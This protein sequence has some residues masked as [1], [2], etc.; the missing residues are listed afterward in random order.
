MT[1]QLRVV[2]Q[3]T[4]ETVTEISTVPSS[5]EFYGGKGVAISYGN[6]MHTW[7]GRWKDGDILPEDNIIMEWMG[8]SYGTITHIFRRGQ[9]VYPSIE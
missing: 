6:G 4:L 2:R 8:P 1:E 9:Q 5:H 3:V 7:D